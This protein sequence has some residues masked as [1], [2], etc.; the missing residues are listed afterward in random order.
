MEEQ[1][2]Q[3][4]I[5]KFIALQE[6]LTMMA[7]PSLVSETNQESLSEINHIIEHLKTTR[8]LLSGL[9]DSDTE[10]ATQLGKDLMTITTELLLRVV[11]QIGQ[12]NIQTPTLE[13]LIGYVRSLIHT[14]SAHMRQTIPGPLLIEWY[15]LSRLMSSMQFEPE[16]RITT[17]KAKQLLDITNDTAAWAYQYLSNQ[18]PNKN[19]IGFVD[20]NSTPYTNE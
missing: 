19:Q 8:E 13:S 10:N 12:T 11:K 3:T 17:K 9:N 1:R 16:L 2:Q 20:R 15:A 6:A 4:R 14:K 7:R 18:D 5:N